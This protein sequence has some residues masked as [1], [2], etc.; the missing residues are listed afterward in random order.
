MNCKLFFFNLELV[1]CLIW[2]LIVYFGN[3][4]YPNYYRRHLKYR[5]YKLLLIFFLLIKSKNY[6]F[7]YLRMEKFLS[8]QNIFFLYLILKTSS[9]KNGKK[10]LH[11]NCEKNQ[12]EGEIRIKFHDSIH[13]MI[14]FNR[15]VFK[16][17]QFRF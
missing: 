17:L 11:K 5:I 2:C 4:S 3:F 9:S 13:S 16:M 12:K 8:L 7:I 6:C 10:S 15:K 14:T 1:S